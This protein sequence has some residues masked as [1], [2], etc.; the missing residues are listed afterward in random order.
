MRRHYRIQ[1]AATKDAKREAYATAHAD[2]MRQPNPGDCRQ[3][4]PLKTGYA[5][6]DINW[7]MRPRRGNVRQWGAFDANDN[8]GIIDG[9]H[10]VGGKDEILRAAAK[11]L[12]SY[13]G[14]IR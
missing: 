13:G 4:W 3:P 6:V 9:R 5:D 1:S 8:P 2:E 10:I 7:T 11:L 14:M 12:P